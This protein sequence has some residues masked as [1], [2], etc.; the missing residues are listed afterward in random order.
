MLYQVLY[1]KFHSL[2]SGNKLKILKKIIGVGFNP[3]PKGAGRGCIVY[4]KPIPNFLLT[5]IMLTFYK[6]T[7]LKG[8][9]I[10]ISEIHKK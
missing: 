7:F 5:K 2:P 8:N 10:N 9:P 4:S 3:N 1:F 6:Y